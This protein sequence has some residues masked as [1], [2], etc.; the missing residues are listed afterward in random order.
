MRC[1]ACDQDIPEAVKFCPECGARQ[2]PDTPPPAGVSQ[3]PTVAP[4]AGEAGE[5]AAAGGGPGLSQ[6]P[7]QVTPGAP[8]PGARGPLIANRYEVLEELGRGGMGVV[9]KVR[10]HKLGGRVVALKRILDADDQGV[11]RFLREA[12]AIAALNHQNIR[13][14]HDRGE[15]AEGPYLVM[16]YVAGETLHDRVAREG[17]LAGEDLVGLARGLGRAL[18]Y[19]H[20]RGVIHR[21]VKPA[22]VLLTEEGEP[23]LTDF[24]LARIGRD[25][26]L[27]LTGYGMGTQD[28]ASPEQRRDAK[29]ADHRSDLYGLGATLYF[30]ATGEAP[31]VVRPE[32][33]PAE[34]RE[35]V[36]RCLEERPEARY[37]SAEEVLGALEALKGGRAQLAAPPVPASGAPSCASCGHSNPED[38]RYCRSCGAGLYAACPKCGK[39]DRV[40]AAYCTSCGVDVAAWRR[41]EEHVGAARRHLE[42]HHYGRA[43]K[44]A[45]AA[46]EAVPGRADA[47]EVL[48]KARQRKETLDGLK[49]KARSKEAEG[50]LEAAEDAWE[51]AL[52]L[53]PE[54]AGLTEAL[55]EVRQR[56]HQ[57][58]IESARKRLEAALRRG[59]PAVAR[60]AWRELGSLEAP[61]D[62]LAELDARTTALEDVVRRRRTVRLL[63]WTAAL[64]VAAG[65]AGAYLSW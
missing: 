55:A 4:A 29:S 30:A 59:Q 65:G 40:G 9:Y 31:K 45:E 16:E 11:Q 14:I 64:V 61:P 58:A 23:K 8:P 57:Q 13:A 5:A 1:P 56:I 39:E 62:L 34:W 42:A 21:D 51:M 10:D 18:A 37:F 46:L 24:G 48:A 15:D 3:A 33:L 43:V 53:A 44:E 28:Y 17:A 50:D 52:E 6:V 47:Q 19:A 12:D 2:R 35:L 49:R 38:A 26:D 32:R 36:L 41:A 60:S 22:N 25:S 54:D 7:T 20:R 63:V 27:S